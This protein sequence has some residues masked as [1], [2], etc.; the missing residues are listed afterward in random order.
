MDGPEGS[1]NVPYAGTLAGPKGD[2]YSQ[3]HL[4]EWGENVCGQED[5]QL[6]TLRPASLVV[7]QTLW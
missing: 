6:L 4:H 5:A 3:S 7:G 2:K 1:S